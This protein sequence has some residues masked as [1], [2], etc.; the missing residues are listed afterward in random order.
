MIGV[1]YLKAKRKNIRINSVGSIEKSKIKCSSFGCSNYVSVKGKC[2]LCE[3][4]A[5]KKRNKDYKVLQDKKKY[6]LK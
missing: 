3:S 1:N 2:F 5:I 6:G 4:K